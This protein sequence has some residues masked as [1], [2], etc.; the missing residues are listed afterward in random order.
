[1]I[2]RNLHTRRLPVPARTAGALIDGLSG[3]DDRLWPAG[4]PRMAF[5]SGFVPGAH[6]GHGPVRYRIAAHEPGRCVRFTFE[7]P[8]RG[9]AAGLVGEH[10]FEVEPAGP[11]ACVLRHVIEGEAF[12]AMLLKWPLVIRPLHDA[13]VE[14]ALDRAELHLTGGVTAPARWSRWVRLLRK[15]VR[16]RR[17]MASPSGRR[18]RVA[19]TGGRPTRSPAPLRRR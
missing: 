19:A 7:P 5:D 9:L 6:G 17:S 2:V 4:W 1:M 12:G 8:A 18:A 11:D 10:R 14:D 15:A 16:R 13:L 3:P